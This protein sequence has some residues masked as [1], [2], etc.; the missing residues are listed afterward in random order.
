MIGVIMGLLH[1]IPGFT[2]LAQFVVGKVYD[3]KVQMYCARWGVTRNVAVAAIQADAQIQNAKVGWIAA[4]ANNPYMMIIVFGFALP[5]IIYEWK[6]IVYDNV[7]AYWGQYTTP[8][9]GGEVG[10]WGG[11]ILSGIFIT[12]GGMGIAHAVINRKD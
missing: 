8:A 11:I 7:W 10:S 5:P 6:V 4:L 3:S 12:S 9:I 1:L 2:S